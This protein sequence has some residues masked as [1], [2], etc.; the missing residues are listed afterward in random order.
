MPSLTAVVSGRAR[1]GRRGRALG[2]QQSAG[3][4]ARVVG[5]IVGGLAFE[6]AGV[7]SPYVGGAVL[8][9]ACAA[10]AGAGR[11]RAE[12]HGVGGRGT[13]G[14]PAGAAAPPVICGS[15]DDH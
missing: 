14:V 8:M 6:H 11:G 4:L 10:L 15:E 2:I 3:G 1:A 7:A 9:A 5:P 13:L 12:G